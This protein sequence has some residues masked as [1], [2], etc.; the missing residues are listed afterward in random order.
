MFTIIIYNDLEVIFLKRSEGIICGRIHSIRMSK[1]IKSKFVAAQLGI[2]VQ[3]YS[4][5]EKGRRL[6]SV[7]RAEKIA[8]ILEL[9]IEALFSDEKLNDF[10]IKKQFTTAGRPPDSLRTTANRG[11]I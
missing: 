11:V 1:G 7:E 6:L 2:T 8:E 5:I 3:S 10:L 9:P 4:D